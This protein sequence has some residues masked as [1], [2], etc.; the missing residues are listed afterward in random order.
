MIYIAKHKDSRYTNQF[1]SIE[2]GFTSNQKLE[3]SGVIFFTFIFPFSDRELF[4]IIF[5]GL[6]NSKR[7][8]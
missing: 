6:K 4:R 7:V 5:I 3:F 1:L 2:M 8:R